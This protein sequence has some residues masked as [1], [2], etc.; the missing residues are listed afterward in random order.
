MRSFSGSRSMSDMT[1]NASTKTTLPPVIMT[2]LI[3]MAASVAIAKALGQV[4]KKGGT[5]EIRVKYDKRK[6]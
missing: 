6:C 3:G 4:A 2:Q 1:G 5:V